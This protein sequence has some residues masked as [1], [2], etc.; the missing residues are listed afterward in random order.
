M[1]PSKSNTPYFVYL[2]ECKDKSIY[3][4]ITTDLKR[5]LCEHKDGRGARYTRTHGVKKMIYW[6]RC[7]TLG[8]ALKREGGIK[9]WPRKRK[10]E[11]VARSRSR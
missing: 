8:E 5:R 10:L 7:G 2:L 6:E 11:L 9:R 3:T 1:T 4:G